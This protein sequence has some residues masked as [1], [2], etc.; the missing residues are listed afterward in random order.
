MTNISDKM[1]TLPNAGGPWIPSL[2]VDG[3]THGKGNPPEV[4]IKV[5]EEHGQNG[6]VISGVIAWIEVERQSGAGGVWRQ[7]AETHWTHEEVTE[8]KKQLVNVLSAELVVSVKEKDK[9]FVTNRIGADKQLR[10]T[11]EIKDIISILEYLSERSLMP[12][13]LASSCQ[14]M[15]SPKSLGSVN[16]EASMGEM[17]T[18]VLSLETCMLSYMESNK[19]Q[20]ETLTEIVTEQRRIAK[21]SCETPNK[22]RRFQEELLEPWENASD[23]EIVEVSDESFASRAAGIKPLRRASFSNQGPTGSQ[24][25]LKTMLKNAME[26]KQAEKEKESEKPKVRKMFH[27][28]ARTTGEETAEEASLAADV[29]L[30]AFGVA[31]DAE[32]E[33]LKDF[34]IAKGIKVIDVQCMTKPELITEGKV[35]SKSMKVTVKAAEHEKAMNPDLWPMRVGVRYFKAPSRRPASGE[36]GWASQAAGSGGQQGQGQG[37]H[38]GAHGPGGLRQ[39]DQRQ[40]GRQH[41]GGQHGGRQQHGGGQHQPR[42]PPPG[43]REYGRNKRNQYQSVGGWQVPLTVDNMFEALSELISSP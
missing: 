35:R 4:V 23:T 25:M 9:E 40:G 7:V 10:K 3:E 15:K 43:S 2:S 39:G 28:N 6:I 21:T 1:L 41:G 38:G 8:A 33:Q 19:Q 32:P 26:K 20:I 5:M 17:Q 31:K 29:D 11:R 12:L 18:K 34:L 22:K 14:M 37:G 16:P 27:G 42:Q 24:L 30:V 36:G 13:V